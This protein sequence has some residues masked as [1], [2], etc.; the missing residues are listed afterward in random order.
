MAIT[1]VTNQKMYIMRGTKY[2]ISRAELKWIVAALNHN[3]ADIKAEMDQ[4]E[5]YSPIYAIGEVAVEGRER[6]VTLLNDIIYNK[7]KTIT[8]V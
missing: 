3:I 1:K 4:A 2:K 7:I 5:D 6:L 8:I